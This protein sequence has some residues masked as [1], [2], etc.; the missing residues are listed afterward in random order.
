MIKRWGKN[1]KERLEK[2]IDT[3]ISEVERLKKIVNDMLLL[4]RAEKEESGFK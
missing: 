1:D 2:S 4:S 3:C